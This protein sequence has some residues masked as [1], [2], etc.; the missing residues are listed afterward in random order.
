MIF[1]FLL[2]KV[3]NPYTFAT[4]VFLAQ[5]QR[6]KE[7]KKQKQNLKLNKQLHKPIEHFF[8]PLVNHFGNSSKGLRKI[9]LGN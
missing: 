6:V 7:K 8:F 2:L 4:L 1:T 5:T 9:L 3:F